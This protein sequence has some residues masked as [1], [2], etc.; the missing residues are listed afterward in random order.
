MGLTYAKE[1]PNTFYR[2]DRVIYQLN[3][4]KIRT[5]TITYY[6]YGYSYLG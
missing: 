3:D 6:F 1:S 4:N 5:N 2:K